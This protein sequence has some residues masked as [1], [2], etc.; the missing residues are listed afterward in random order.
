MFYVYG[1]DDGEERSHFVE[2]EEPLQAALL[3]ESRFSDRPGGAPIAREMWEVKR[4]NG[5]VI[6]V[7]ALAGTR[8]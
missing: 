2:A 6:R 3:F 1:A 7:L 5:G 4:R 8:G